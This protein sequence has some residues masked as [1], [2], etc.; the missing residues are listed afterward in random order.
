[1]TTHSFLLVRNVWN[2]LSTQIMVM[3]TLPTIIPSR[4]KKKMLFSI[5]AVRQSLERTS[6]LQNDPRPRWCCWMINS[7]VVAQD[8]KCIS[9]L[10]LNTCP[11]SSILETWSS[12][13]VSQPWT[14]MILTLAN[15]ETISSNVSSERDVLSA[16]LFGNHL[17]YIIPWLPYHG[18]FSGNSTSSRQGYL[19][20][21]RHWFPDRPNM[22]DSW[23]SKPFATYIWCYGCSWVVPLRYCNLGTRKSL[24]QFDLVLRKHRS[25]KTRWPWY[26]LGIS[27]C[28]YNY[29]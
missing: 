14:M 17:N 15:S 13:F 29:G 4:R 11:L 10:F 7:L 2:G 12:E 27:M 18:W 6:Y 26:M 3:L 25:H 9:G 5:L 22:D 1:M 21:Q 19:F 20:L 23:I 8:K 28:F 24:S 16:T